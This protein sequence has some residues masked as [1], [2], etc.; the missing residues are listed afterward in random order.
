MTRSLG[1]LGSLNSG[2]GLNEVGFG[3]AL[4]GLSSGIVIGVFLSLLAGVTSLW[5]SL[6]RFLETGVLVE[7]GNISLPNDER[8]VVTAWG[9]SV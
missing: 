4:D 9:H 5:L 2:V 8:G 3:S 1:K 7:G 6:A